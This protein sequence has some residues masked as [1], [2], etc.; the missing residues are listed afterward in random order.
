MQQ[1]FYLILQYLLQN[2]SQF[3]S[4]MI[5]FYS[6]IYLFD[7]KN[8]SMLV[9]GL[10][11][12]RI[13]NGLLYPTLFSIFVLFQPQQFSSQQ[14]QPFVPSQSPSR[15][16]TLAQHDDQILPPA[17][18]SSGSGAGQSSRGSTPNNHRSHTNYI[19]PGD[20]Y[21]DA[22]TSGMKPPFAIMCKY[23]HCITK[24]KSD[25]YRH[26]SERHFKAELAKELPCKAPFK[27]PMTG[28]AF[29]ICSLADSG[30][31]LDWGSLSFI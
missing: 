9:F 11:F 23:C 28:K 16:V 12:F 20:D 19:P 7:P 26:L 5:D 4:A 1:Y 31:F 17:A 24:N 3:K 21:I 8:Y 14:G 27:C 2:F 13:F 18:P 15:P 29:R 6:G 30:F 25:F 10:N 22:P